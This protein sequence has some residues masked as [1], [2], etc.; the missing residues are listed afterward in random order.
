M[1]VFLGF[2]VLFFYKIR[3]IPEHFW[4]AR[5]FLAVSLPGACLL[6]GTAAFPFRAV[7]PPTILV[8]RIP[9]LAI[10]AAGTLV[11]LSIGAVYLN[12]STVI[13]RHIEYE[14]IV[15]RI[16][17]INDRISDTDLVLV[18]SRQASDL[19]TLALPLAYIYARQVLV[20]HGPHPPAAELTKFLAWARGRFERILFIGGGGTLL[21]SAS[22]DAIPLNS[23]TFSVPEY[24]SA[25]HAYPREAR[26]KRYD[27]AIYE[28]VPRLT[29][30]ADFSL[31]V[32]SG[33]ELLLRRFHD[34]ETL[35]GTGTTFRWSRDRSLVSLLGISPDRSV[36]TL[37]LNNGGRPASAGLAIVEVLLNR[38][39]LG[40]VTVADQFEP[41]RF[42]IPPELA[43]EIADSGTPALLELLTST[44]NPGAVLGVDD[45]RELGVMVDRITVE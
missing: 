45:P 37:R 5:R 41:Y 6:I 42:D 22:T 44:W 2:S 3:I 17:A 23:E 33:D 21:L 29:E 9:R 25:Y 40:T 18:E 14:D 20:F 28:L 24:E 38:R 1:L 7:T 39:T 27:V 16:E 34:Q 26:L 8:R 36:L 4:A 10:A 43:G 32:G 35:G 30:L 15:P 19:H 31:D 13:M 12:A 11:V